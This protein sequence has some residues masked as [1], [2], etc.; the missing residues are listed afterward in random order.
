MSV[1]GD[2]KF[3]ARNEGKVRIRGR[4][5]FCNGGMVNF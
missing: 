2:G 3:F 5:W 1:R 4:Y